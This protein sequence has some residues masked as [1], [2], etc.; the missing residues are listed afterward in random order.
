M[1]L[2]RQPTGRA[3]SAFQH[4]CR[5]GRFYSGRDGPIFSLEADPAAYAGR[6]RLAAPCAAKAF[7]AFLGESGAPLRESR[8]VTW[9]RYADQLETAASLGFAGPRTLVIFSETAL[10]DGSALLAFVVR[11]L[12]LK[13]FDF[14]SLPTF[15]DSAGRETLREPGPL[16][17]A[18]AFYAAHNFVAA[19]RHAAPPLGD[20][21][22]AR[23]DAYYERPNADLEAYLA[24]AG[25]DVAV[26]PPRKPGRRLLPASWS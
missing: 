5:K 15:R 10:L 24:A 6:K 17:A 13:A 1:L 4:H 23:L 25:R 22:R 2:L 9:G 14:S 19:A 11:W 16:G 20:E 21:T 26:Y 7:E 8:I 12:G 18:K 3:Y